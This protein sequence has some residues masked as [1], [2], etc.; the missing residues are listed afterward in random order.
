MIDILKHLHNYL[1]EKNSVPESTLF[2]GD[3]LTVERCMNVEEDVRDAPTP[4]KQLSALKPVSEDFHTYR[5]FLEVSCT[6]IW[7][8][9]KA[10]SHSKKK[11]IRT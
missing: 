6:T 4:Q 7:V 11:E 5:N 2:G 3:L 1:P 9:L 8:N 10:T